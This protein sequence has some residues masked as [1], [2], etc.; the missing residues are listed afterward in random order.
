M[1]PEQLLDELSKET[2][3]V[4][5]AMA[6]SKDIQEKEAYSRII[7]NLCEAQ[8]VFFDF[9]A[10]VMGDDETV[11]DYADDWEDDNR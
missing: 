2:S 6:Q 10:N 4:L 7:K 1:E 8:G 11:G 9:L 5:R 3:V